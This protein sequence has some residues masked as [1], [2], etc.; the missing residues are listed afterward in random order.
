MCPG[1]SEKTRIGWKAPEGAIIEKVSDKA[2]EP[3]IMQGTVNQC[4]NGNW[5]VYLPY[6][7]HIKFFE[8]EI[9]EIVIKRTVKP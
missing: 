5:T 6:S 3:M 2:T 1:I 4:I 8:D 7:D 9:V